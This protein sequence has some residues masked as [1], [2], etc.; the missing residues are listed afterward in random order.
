LPEGPELTHAW[1]RIREELHREVEDSAYQLW[2][3]P[4]RPQALADGALVLAA[5]PAICSWVADRYA[6]VLAA[7]AT[8]VLGSATSVSVVPASPGAVPAPPGRTT[9][10]ADPL[11]HRPDAAATFH[12]KYA[13]EQFVIGD[14]NRLAHAAALAV[15]ELPGH[16]YNPLFIYGTPGLGKTHLLH[17]IGN[18]LIDSGSGLSVRY[19]TAETFTNGF[20]SAIHDGGADRFKARYR[21]NDVLLVDDVQFLERKAKTEEEFFHTFNALQEAGSQLVL[22][23]DRLPRDLGGL[24]ER[25]RERFEA[26]LVTDL[27][28]PD[29][30]TRLTILRKRVERDRIPLP[31]DSA[32]E[33]IARRITGNMRALEGALIR[34]VALH[35]LTDRALD[36]SLATEVLD[37]LYPSTRA[38]PRTTVREIQEATCQAFGLTLE[39]LLSATRTRRV[40]WPR[41]VAMYLARELTDGTLP[42]IGQAFGGRNHATVLHAC[43]RTKERMSSDHEALDAVHSLSRRVGEEP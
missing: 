2:L 10:A 1:T 36:A 18:Y 39:E 33:V 20:L 22:T 13:F 38:A 27:E 28:P 11:P 40:A 12:P 29:L 4:L 41:Q 19:A 35:S 24:E 9:P 25:L 21:N 3:E 8:S 7:A 23:S 15:A 34:V 31:D 6:R 43:Q 26:G 30:S 17:A 5:P 42:A 14:S 37:T 32:L 16:A